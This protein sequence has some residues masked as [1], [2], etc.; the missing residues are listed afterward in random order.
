MPVGTDRAAYLTVG[1][2]PQ[3]NA[4]AT[5]EATARA[6]GVATVPL[7]DGGRAFQDA[8]R[9]TS[10]YAAFPGTDVQI[11]VF[12]PAEGVALRT[13]T[14]GALA[15]LGAAQGEPAGTV[16][17]KLVTADQLRAFAAGED[18]PV[19]WAGARSGSRYEL[20]RTA[21]GRVYVRYLPAGVEAGTTDA[22]YLTVGTYP[23]ADAAR[24][25]EQTV[26]RRGAERVAV[27]GGIAGILRGNPDSVYVAFPGVDAQ[28]EV[29]APDGGARPLVEDGRVVAVR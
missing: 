3:R 2:Y 25:L 13:I 14:S 10:A 1:S 18:G 21:D 23:Q 29:F 8:R 5:L 16:A 7:P 15:R 11:E 12:D 27:P 20:T 22:G 9:P 4:L 28:V 17:P 26:S 6:Q 24:T 19:Y